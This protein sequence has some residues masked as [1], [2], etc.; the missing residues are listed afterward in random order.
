MDVQFAFL[1]QLTDNFAVIVFTDNV[2]PAIDPVAQQNEDQRQDEHKNLDGQL[3]ARI[4][5]FSSGIPCFY[6]R[7]Q[8]AEAGQ[9]HGYSAADFIDE[10][11]DGESDALIAFAQLELA[12]FHGIR[13]KH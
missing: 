2:L 4:E 7:K 13:Q 8:P 3:S 9:A 12:I 10:G 6:S 11:L 5:D 1:L